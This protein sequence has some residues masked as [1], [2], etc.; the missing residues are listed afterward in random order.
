MHSSNMP[1]QTS[2]AANAAH[3]PEQP[4]GTASNKTSATLV[5]ASVALT[6]FEAW[7]CVVAVYI[8]TRRLVRPAALR[9]S[10]CCSRTAVSP[11]V[12]T[13]PRRRHGSKSLRLHVQLKRLC[14][15]IGDIKTMPTPARGPCMWP[16]IQTVPCGHSFKCEMAELLLPH[17]NIHDHPGLQ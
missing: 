13:M 15:A 5:L 16:G 7:C 8:S 1:A 9:R 11:G 2:V 10:H 6:L 14:T 3:T 17:G 4:R 12:A